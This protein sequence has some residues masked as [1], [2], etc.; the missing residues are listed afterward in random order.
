MPDT[1]AQAGV[2]T[3]SG[4]A[5]DAQVHLSTA[6]WPVWASQAIR[7]AK[8]ARIARQRL[9]VDPNSWIGETVSSIQ[10]ICCAAFARSGISVRPWPSAA[11]TGSGRNSCHSQPRPDRS[12]WSDSTWLLS[13]R[14]RSPVP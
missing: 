3:A 1:N 11:S 5:F 8:E 9:A 13:T 7:H 6:L 4:A 10:A 2:A 12:R 14:S